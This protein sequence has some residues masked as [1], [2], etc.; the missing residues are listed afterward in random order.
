MRIGSVLENQE[1]EKRISITPDV[2]KKYTSLGFEVLL[3]ENYGRHIGINDDEYLKLGVKISKD[4]S[5]I[6]SSSDIIVQLGMLSDEKSSIIKESQILIGVLNPYDNKDKLESLAKKKIKLFSLELLPR[7][8]RAQSMDILS[9]QANLAG[10]KAVIE[11]FAYFEK[12]IPMM[13]T[14]AGT[15]PAAKVLVVGAGVAGLQAIATAKRMGAIVFATDVRMASKEQVESLG[16]K[17][18]TVEGSENLE[19]EGGYAKE[20]SEDFKNKQ[21]ELLTETL[22]KIDIVI[23]TALIPGKKAPLIIKEKMINDMQSGSVIYDL[24]AIQGG[25]TA[26]TEVN[27]IIEKNGVKIMGESN[28]LNKLPIS[29]SSLYAKNVFNFVDNLFDKKNKKININLEDEIIEKTLIK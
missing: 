13:M 19:T 20:A 17:F 25:N 26:F 5:E 12:A 2:I 1:N 24:A 11:S 23:C 7:I 8:T 9:S 18:L 28:I 3:S 10:Y 21:E 15:I 4:D 29:S 16:G 27:K 22:K 14:A 6:L